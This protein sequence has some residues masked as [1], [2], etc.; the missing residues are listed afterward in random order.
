MDIVESVQFGGDSVSQAGFYE[1]WIS[2]SF[3]S[4]IIIFF[5]LLFSAPSVG[6]FGSGAASPSP[7]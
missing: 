4:V 5:L 2:V 3:S 6:S 7:R 1:L